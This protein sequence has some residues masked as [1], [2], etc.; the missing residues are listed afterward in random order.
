MFSDRHLD[1]KLKL[2]L[3]ES[4][5]EGMH[6]DGRGLY[7]QVGKAKARSWI[8]RYAMDGKEWHM[9][10]GP[11][12]TVSLDEA[13]A[14]ALECR[15]QVLAGN[16]PLKVQEQQRVAKKLAEHKDKTF[17]QWATAYRAFKEKGAPGRRPWEPETAKQA[18]TVIR[19][20]LNPTLG[21]LSIGAIGVDEVA[22]A[23]EPIWWSKHATAATTRMHCEKILDYAG[24]KKDDNPATVKSLQHRLHRSDIVHTATHHGSLPHE[25]IGEIVAKLRT[26]QPMNQPGGISVGAKLLEFLILTAVRKDQARLAR[27][28]EFDLDNKRLWT[29]PAMRDDGSQ[30]HKIGKKTKQPHLVPLSD[31]AIAVLMEMRK[32]QAEMGL[33]SDADSYVFQHLWPSDEKQHRLRLLR[34]GELHAGEPINELAPS[35]VLREHLGGGSL[36]NT[37]GGQGVKVHGFRSTFQSWA[38]E[39]QRADDILHEM[40]LGHVVGGPMFRKYGGREADLLIEP[41]RQMMDAWAEYCGRT[42]PLADNIINIRHATA[43]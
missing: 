11:T 32:V 43:K 23:I 31:P 7:L 5:K 39:V 8:F 13:R 12:H 24:V 37:D 26:Y 28:K 1:G 34:G 35:R 9:G 41:R 22:R 20:Y 15:K 14:R 4:M 6:S 19:L 21:K 2:R 25:R 17:E 3:I 27:W 10:L 18:E 29:T 16:N 30:G 38:V 40:A 42:E 33:D 36:S